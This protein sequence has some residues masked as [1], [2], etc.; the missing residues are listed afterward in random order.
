MGTRNAG[1][2]RHAPHTHG[3]RA[4]A[5]LLEVSRAATPV[6]G[7]KL[8]SAVRRQVHRPRGR[9]LMQWGRARGWTLLVV[10]LLCCLLVTVGMVAGVYVMVAR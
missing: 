6:M 4:G 8:L 3:Q 10:G 2:N 5:S 9:G 7:R 1:R